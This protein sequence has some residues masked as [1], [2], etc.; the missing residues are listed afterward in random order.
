MLQ[1]YREH[2]FDRH[3]A[4]STLNNSA[5]AITAYHKM[6]GDVVEIPVLVR[7]DTLPSYFTEEEIA[8]IFAVINNLKHLCMFQVLFCACLRSSELCNLDISDIDINNL[9][10][11]I[12][13]GKGGRDGYAFLN[14]ECAR[15]L[16]LYLSVRPPFEID[17]R[18]PLFYTEYQ[19]RWRRG[20]LYTVFERYKTKAGIEKKGGLHVFGRHSAATIMT[21]KGVPLNIVQKLLRHRDVRTTLRYAH[22]DKAVAREWHNKTMKLD[23]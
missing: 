22:V 10:V 4:R 1:A 23:Y 9:S 8:R 18:E 13:E 6:I 20:A 16:K 14:H 21:S 3:W 11:R 12:V 7:N 19:K 5:F 2:I 15:N 17:G